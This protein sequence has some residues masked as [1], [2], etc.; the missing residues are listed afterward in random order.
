MWESSGDI[1]KMLPW[2]STS[3]RFEIRLKNVNF[4]ST[5]V[6]EGQVQES[7][8]EDRDIKKCFKKKITSY[9]SF[10][11]QF[12]PAGNVPGYGATSG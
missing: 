1:V 5:Q 4:K 11:K 12:C 10:Q 6:I 2:P 7:Y 8:F 3:K 9:F